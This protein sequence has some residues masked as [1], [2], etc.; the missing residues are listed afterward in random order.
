MGKASVTEPI[1]NA[2]PTQDSF[3]TDIHGFEISRH[4][5]AVSEFTDKAEVD[6]VYMPEVIEFV[7]ERTVR[8]LPLISS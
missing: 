4:R 3:R 2:T 5:S 6:S 7:K 1:R 8:L